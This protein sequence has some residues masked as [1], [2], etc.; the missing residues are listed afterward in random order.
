M[1]CDLAFNDFVL[2]F[3]DVLMVFDDGTT[4]HGRE[5]FSDLA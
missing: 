1:M 4:S 2:I 5:C 3:A